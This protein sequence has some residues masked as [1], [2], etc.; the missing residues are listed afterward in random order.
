MVFALFVALVSVAAFFGL[1]QIMRTTHLAQLGERELRLTQVFQTRMT[2]RIRAVLARIRG[3]ELLIGS[4]PP[5]AATATK[6]LVFAMDRRNKREVHS[7]AV[8]LDERAR[9]LASRR[10]RGIPP[11]NSA[12][13]KIWSRA[14][15]SL[16]TKIRGQSRRTIR[17]AFH[18][19]AGTIKGVPVLFL[20]SPSPSTKG[21]WGIVF[22]AENL[23]SLKRG[24]LGPNDSLFLLSEPEQMVLYARQ[25]ERFFQDAIGRP[26]EMDLGPTLN[27]SACCES[28][29]FNTIHEAQRWMS[30]V[31]LSGGT[32]SLSVVRVAD[33]TSEVV[34]QA[35]TE[36]LISGGLFFGWVML[37]AAFAVLGRGGSNRESEYG[38]PQVDFDTV[39]S[40]ELPANTP[41]E[42]LARISEFVA[43][44]DHF[45]DVIQFGTQETARFLHADRFYSALYDDELDQLFEISCSN[46]GESYRAAIA[47][48][49]GELPEHIAVKERDFVEVP[50]MTEWEGAP[51]ALKKE[52]VAAVAVFPLRIG[53]KIVGLMSFYFNQPRELQAEE[54]EICGFFALQGA[55]AVARALS[56]A[57]LPPEN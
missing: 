5:S 29:A 55:S 56:I 39:M 4:S 50:S 7:A 21:Y 31:S 17:N 15:A 45:R 12:E 42:A 40:N 22:P 23:L 8:V 14:V 19:E 43:R 46:L 57:E 47:I 26:F 24:E 54:A 53:E 3:A 41:F 35:R 6:A 36:V 18:L 34:V 49:S 48:G 2:A 44:G 9:V 32:R 28:A 33:N 25:G 30:Q 52:G 1:R 27:I 13:K 51:D 16:R 20:A 11:P 10:R 37:V 38:A